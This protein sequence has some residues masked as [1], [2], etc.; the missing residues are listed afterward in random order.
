MARNPEWYE[1]NEQRSWPLAD[2]ATLFDDTGKRMP[3][4]LIADLNI[5]FPSTVGEYAFLGA[6]T[7]G[8]SIA[9]V[10]ILGTASGTPPIAAVSLSGDIDPYRHYPLESLY[11]GVGGWIVFGSGLK[12]EKIKS[13]RFSTSGQ[14]ILM[15]QVARKY[16]PTLVP[17]IAT[18]QNMDALTGIVRLK[19]GDDIEIV[20]ESREIDNI[21]RDVAVI[22]LKL[23]PEFVEDVN[24]LE[25]YA[26]PCGKRPESNNCEYTSPIEFVNSVAPDCCGNI[27]IEF[28]GCADVL[29]VQNEPCAVAISCN[30]GLS[31]ACTTPDRLPDSTGRLPNTFDAQCVVEDE[32]VISEEAVAEAVQSK[33]TAEPPM[34]AE[35][36]LD[37]RLPYREDFSTRRAE[38][39]R[40]VSGKF[41]IVSDNELSIY[42]GFSLQST[43]A[44][45]CLAVWRRGAP[46]SNW[47]SYNKKAT[48]HMSMRKGQLGTLHNGGLVF[49][50]NEL[51]QTGWALELDIEGTF[52]RK[53]V[54]VALYRQSAGVTYAHVPIRNLTTNMQYK[55]ELTVLPASIPD[56]AWIK[57]TV[58][59][60]EA[61]GSKL[62]VN[63]VV[64]PILLTGYG[65]P[66]GLFGMCAYRAQTQFNRLVVD[67]VEVL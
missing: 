38:D 39:M 53:G 62:Y 24:L 4:Q 60:S 3:N 17:S 61:P 48:L 44:N 50:Y 66:E 49:N 30:Q 20:K 26:G 14:S 36:V 42:G 37:E 33:A 25:K 18:S 54:R 2:Q 34:V 1:L 15:P 55:L 28:R 52:G 21:V 23:K 47:T 8:P 63:T 22:R 65:P 10:T 19:G 32:S 35:F 67:N 41:D 45:R 46:Q 31:D 12:E 56:S 11:P 51:T 40:F 5:W 13:F 9:T 64:E 59:N 58:T 6:V 29:F 27:T 16:P 43:T 57:A 7:L